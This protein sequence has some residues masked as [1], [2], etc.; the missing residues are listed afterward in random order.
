MW[1]VPSHSWST[2]QLLDQTPSYARYLRCKVKQFPGRDRRIQGMFFIRI[3]SHSRS[4][5]CTSSFHYILDPTS[6]QCQH[7]SRSVVE[8]EGMHKDLS[9]VENMILWRPFA[10]IRFPHPLSWGSQRI[11]NAMILFAVSA[12]F[13]ERTFFR[14][15][16]HW[17]RKLFCSTVGY[18]HITPLSS[19]RPKSLKLSR[20]PM[21]H[22]NQ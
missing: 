17:V 4:D 14:T 19:R 3:I 9:K 1:C 2:D 11:P 13:E 10:R 20:K 22:R 8:R 21:R 18:S 16:P 5:L 7:S 6:H 15:T 12:L